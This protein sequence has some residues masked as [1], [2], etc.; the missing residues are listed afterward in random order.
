MGGG[1]AS[2]DRCSAGTGYLPQAPRPSGQ[3]LFVKNASKTAQ[4]HSIPII[5][6]YLTPRVISSH[7]KTLFSLPY[8]SVL[9]TGRCSILATGRCFH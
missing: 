7:T 6:I 4:F 2:T 3:S 1:C 8:P 9:T 5:S